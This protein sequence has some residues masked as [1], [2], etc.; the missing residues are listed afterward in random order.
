VH[1]P[2]LAAGVRGEHAR[3][4]DPLRSWKLGLEDGRMRWVTADA[5]GAMV[6]CHR[7]PRASWGRRAIAGLM[8]RL[9]IES[10]L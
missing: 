2:K 4:T 5:G 7:E 8:R 10:Q 1:H 6:T 9:P 3:L